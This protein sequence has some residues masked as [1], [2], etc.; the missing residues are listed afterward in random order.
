[1]APPPPEIRALPSRQSIGTIGLVT[2]ETICELTA[3]RTEQVRYYVSSAEPVAELHAKAF[4]KHRSIENQ[5][6][7]VWTSRFGRTRRA[8]GISYQHRIRRSYNA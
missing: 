6:L 8:F 3:R 4:R 5:P 2:T 7:W 1:M